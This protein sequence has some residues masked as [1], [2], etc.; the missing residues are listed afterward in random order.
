[1]NIPYPQLAGTIAVLKDA[2]REDKMMLGFDARIQQLSVSDFHF[3]DTHIKAF[4]FQE[5]NQAQQKAIVLLPVAATY[6]FVTEEAHNALKS[7]RQSPDVAIDTALI[8]EMHAHAGFNQTFGGLVEAMD[9][10]DWTKV[11]YDPLYAN[12]EAES[13]EDKIAFNRLEW[14]VEQLSAFAQVSAGAKAAVAELAE[15]HWQGQPMEVQ[16]PGVLQGAYVVTKTNLQSSI[17]SENMNMENL[18]FLK[19]LIKDK[20]FGEGL[21]PE[22]EKNIQAQTKN[23]ELAFTTQISNRPFEASLAFRKSDSSEM[24]FFN[25]YKASIEKTNGQ[26]TEQNF[27]IKKGRGM[28]TREAYNQL[29]GRAV[30]KDVVNAKGEEYKEWKQLDFDKKDPYGNYAENKYNDGYGYDLRAA[31]AKFPVAELDGGD[32]EKDLIRSLERG[33]AQSATID[34]N[35]EPMKVFLEANPKYKTVNVY[36]EHFKMLKH[37]ELPMIQKPGEQ[38]QQQAVEGPADV[39][40]QSQAKDV[41]VNGKEP[42]KKAARKQVKNKS[43]KQNKGMQI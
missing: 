42:A 16:I 17:K 24:Y 39:K 13:I 33:N 27:Q 5:F 23:F 21:Y 2:V 8:S 6:D 9:S 19:K 35:G 18:E 15:R 31:V 29:Q 3:F 38:S 4:D 1:M 40:Q 30:R 26:K 32:K 7:G 37:E 41:A 12:V 11:F 22:L 28:T 20:G 36:D 34:N 10:F 25:S 14:L 43:S